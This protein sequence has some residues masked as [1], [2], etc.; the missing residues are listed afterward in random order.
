MPKF[1]LFNG[2]FRKGLLCFPGCKWKMKE[3]LEEIS[4]LIGNISTVY[5]AQ[6]NYYLA[7]VFIELMLSLDHN[8]SEEKVKRYLV[9][10]QKCQ[11]KF[12]LS[13]NDG[14]KKEPN[15]ESR[16]LKINFNSTIGRHGIA[17]ENIK[18]GET[19]LTDNPTSCS[20]Q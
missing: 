5:F 8:F 17:N 1:L 4:Q 12:Q 18:P 13:E 3:D 11:T 6:K 10:K 7:Y 19:I 9:R 14:V 15:F 16:K 2:L 20:L